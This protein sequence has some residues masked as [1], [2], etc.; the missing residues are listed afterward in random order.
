[1]VQGLKEDVE[2][3]T[4]PGVK[5]YRLKEC[6]RRL[7]WWENVLGKNERVLYIYSKCLDT[8]PTDQSLVRLIS[9][10]ACSGCLFY[11]PD[12]HYRCEMFCGD[13]EALPPVHDLPLQIQ[14]SK[15]PEGFLIQLLLQSQDMLS[16]SSNQ[17]LCGAPIT[18]W[19]NCLLLKVKLASGV[20]QTK[21][22]AR[23][24]WFST[25]GS[26]WRKFW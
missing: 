16:I 9:T 14:S 1:M 17:S 6:K 23:M 15:K 12:S 4:Q 21:Q 24:N 2:E 8:P 19:L 22:E 11:S 20:G 26:L 10:M 18:W 25:M 3:K 13:H 5:E 7:T